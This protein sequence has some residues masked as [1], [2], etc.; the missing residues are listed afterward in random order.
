VAIDSP[1]S[2]FAGP[3]DHGVAGFTMKIVAAFMPDGLE[4]MRAKSDMFRGEPRSDDA[5]ARAGLLGVELP[6]KVETTLVFAERGSQALDY[7]EKPVSP[8][9]G[10]LVRLYT[11][12]EPV[13][14]DQRIVNFWRALRSARVAPAFD[15]DAKALAAAGSL[16]EA[17]LLAALERHFPRF[18]GDHSSVIGER[19]L[20][21]HLDAVLS[22]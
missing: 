10:K 19:S 16:D 6:A 12:D 14:G 7:T 18:P 22:K 4:D 13:E 9:V 3:S 21:E 1:W 20:L 15:A 17:S 2:G 11:R 5:A 8:L